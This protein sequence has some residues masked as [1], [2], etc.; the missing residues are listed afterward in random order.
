MGSQGKYI[1]WSSGGI[2]QIRSTFARN[3]SKQL[4]KLEVRLEIFSRAYLVHKEVYHT[5]RKSVWVQIITM[6]HM[7]MPIF[8][9]PSILRLIS[10]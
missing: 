3:I 1:G 7:Y 4:K 6:W 2:T 10:G 9:M 8:V 5:L